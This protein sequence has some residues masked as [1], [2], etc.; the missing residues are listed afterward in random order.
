MINTVYGQFNTK[1]IQN[2][3]CLLKCLKCMNHTFYWLYNYKLLINTIEYKSI[4]SIW[5]SQLW[6]WNW[7]GTVHCRSKIH[8]KVVYYNE[9][10]LGPIWYGP[11]CMTV[12]IWSISYHGPYHLVHI[13]LI[14]NL[15]LYWTERGFSLKRDLLYPTFIPGGML[16]VNQRNNLYLNEFQLIPTA[17]RLLKSR[18]LI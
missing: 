14:Y 18:I 10:S 3:K 5:I 2:V 8:S 12:I 17:I 7:T 11:Y 16:Y 6:V 15:E 4:L 1:L 13:S 9:F